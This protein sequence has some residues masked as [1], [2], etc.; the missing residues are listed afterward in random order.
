MKNSKI[1]FILG[2]IVWFVLLVFNNNFYAVI[3]NTI[4]IKKLNKQ[5]SSLDTEYEK[6]SKE[7]E[8]ILSGDKSYLE[9]TARVKYNMAMPDE[10][11]F[12]IKETK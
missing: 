3:H 8:K 4:M 6:L 2:A 9:S 1:I 12:R 7:Y 11:E 10:I 5:I